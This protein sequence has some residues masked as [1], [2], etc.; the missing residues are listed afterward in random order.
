VNNQGSFPS[1]E[2][3]FSN[4]HHIQKDSEAHPASYPTG[5]GGSFPRRKVARI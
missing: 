4:Q 1:R 2:G 5:T 3:I